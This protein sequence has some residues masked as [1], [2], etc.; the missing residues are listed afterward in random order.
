MTCARASRTIEKGAF[1]GSYAGAKATVAS[2]L[3]ASSC[4]RTGS[5]PRTA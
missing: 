1:L 4:S 3:R 5:I 2:R